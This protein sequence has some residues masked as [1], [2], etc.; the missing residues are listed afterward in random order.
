MSK[1]SFAVGAAIVLLSGAFE[2]ASAQVLMG[3]SGYSFPTA[4]TFAAQAQISQRL[5]G[6]GSGQSS[7]MQALTEYIYNSSSTSVGNINNMNVGDNSQATLA[8]TQSNSG[9]QG[10]TATTDVKNT[11]K[12]NATLNGGQTVNLTSG[13]STPPS[14]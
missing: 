14:Q 11:I 9:S 1:I 10:S 6:S 8:T 12:T 13:S 3:S 4:N 5:N 2:A 7:G